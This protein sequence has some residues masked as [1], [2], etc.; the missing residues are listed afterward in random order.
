MFNIMPIVW[1]YKTNEIDY[2]QGN[3]L[4]KLFTQGRDGKKKKKKKLY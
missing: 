3:M 1:A 2:F 4:P